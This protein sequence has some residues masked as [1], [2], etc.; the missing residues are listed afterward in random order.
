MSA[1]ASTLTRCGPPKRRGWVRGF[2]GRVLMVVVLA[3]LAGWVLHV[4]GHVHRACLRVQ[5]QILEVSRP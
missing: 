1:L 4:V 5:A 3:G 2:L